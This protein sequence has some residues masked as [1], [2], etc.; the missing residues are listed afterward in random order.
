MCPRFSACGVL[1]TRS[2]TFSA[3]SLVVPLTPANHAGFNPWGQKVEAV[4]R[5]VRLQSMLLIMF[6]RLQNIPTLAKL[7]SHIPPGQFG[8]YLAV[9]VFNTVFGYSSYVILTVV[10]TPHVP[11]AYVLA[12]A[13]STVL[14]ITIAFLNY[15]W[16]VFKTKGNYLREWLRC[17]VVYGGGI[18]LAPILLPMT[19]FAIRHLTRADA[20]APYIAGALLMGT[21]VIGSFFG[22]KHFSFGRSSGAAAPS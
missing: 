17:L 19:V 13:L 16:F 5:Q 14:N 11:Y 4:A 10:L 2:T 3:A 1:L 22:H 15:K 21:G 18:L 20:S 7:T 12:G 6:E 9:G 8:R